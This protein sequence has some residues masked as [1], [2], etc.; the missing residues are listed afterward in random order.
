MPFRL[1]NIVLL[2]VVT[3]IAQGEG[4]DYLSRLQAVVSHWHEDLP[5][6]RISA[7]KAAQS[8]IEQG[9]G[10]YLGGN[11]TSFIDE[12]DGRAGGLAGLKRLNPNIVLRSS[13]VV[14]ISVAS[15][16]SGDTLHQQFAQIESAG[17][18][19][20]VFGP[21]PAPHRQ[22]SGYFP[23]AGSDNPPNL[24]SVNNVAGLWI[25]VGEFVSASRRLGKMPCFYESVG[26]PG[27]ADRNKTI[28]GQLF[29][30]GFVTPEAATSLGEAYLITLQK[31]LTELRARNDAALHRATSL[32]RNTHVAG[33]EASL[34]AIGHMFPAEFQN[35]VLPTWIHPVEGSSP[36]LESLVV[37]LG[38]QAFPWDNPTLTGHLRRPAIIISSQGPSSDWPEDSDHIYLDPCWDI[39]DACVSC[40][41]YDIPIL[42]LSGVITCALFWHLMESLNPTITSPTQVASKHDLPQS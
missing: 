30:S 39:H 12:A 41:G 23:S 16:G 24:Q 13:D 17:A 34:L 33:K 38:Y 25:W 40:P 36:A 2:F 7:R 15:S 29:H 20:I 5:A 11:Q 6:L 9:G 1:T 35:A 8:L 28:A 42:P 19:A 31:A 27:G 21:D 18:T 26:I 4:A 32:L 10:L 3:T 37:F 22:N 14:L